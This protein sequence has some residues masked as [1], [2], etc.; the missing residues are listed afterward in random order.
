MTS[1]DSETRI[2]SE[3]TVG[4]L[5]AEF[6]GRDFMPDDPDAPHFFCDFCSKG[7]AYQSKPTVGHY[8]TDDVL[9]PEH[10]V[11]PEEKRPIVPLA[12]YCEE[13]TT[14]RI[15]FPC[16]GFAE[17]RMRFD[18]DENRVLENVEILDVSP[19]DDGI[20]WD[21]KELC[22]KITGVPWDDHRFMAEMLQGDDLWGPENMVTFFLS[23]VKGID[24][25]ELVN[26]K[27]EFNPQKLG[28]ARKKYKEYMNEMQREGH[29]RER[30]RDHVR[31]E[32]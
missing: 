7:V 2:N 32:K 30:F 25:R 26:W 18:L 1:I 21:P 3:W 12:S 8:V 20:P 13:C 17:V 24:I 28:Q 5:I 9:N 14:T 15:L 27:G 4:E 23:A 11:W 16:E 10:P 19:R 31:G 6:E 29:T 22:S